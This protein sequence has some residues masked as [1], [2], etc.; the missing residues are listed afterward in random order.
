MRK[1]KLPVIMALALMCCLVMLTGKS[2]E[3]SGGRKDRWILS[4]RGRF[5]SRKSSTEDA[6]RIP[7]DRRLLDQQ[8]R[9]RKDLCVCIYHSE[10]DR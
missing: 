2:V 7:D 10:H 9:S 4:D 1:R 3:A 8:G 5:I 6:G